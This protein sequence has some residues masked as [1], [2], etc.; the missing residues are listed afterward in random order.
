MEIKTTDELLEM[1]GERVSCVLDGT[2][3]LDGIICVEDGWIFVCQDLLFGVPPYDFMGK[4][5]GWAIASPDCRYEDTDPQN[6]SELRR[7]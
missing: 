5:Y 7:L 1:H 3:I 4:K 2:E 6:C